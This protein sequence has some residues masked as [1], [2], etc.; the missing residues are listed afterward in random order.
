MD[1]A[2]EVSVRSDESAASLRKDLLSKPPD[3]RVITW[4]NPFQRS[5]ELNEMIIRSQRSST[6]SISNAYALCFCKWGM[7]AFILGLCSFTSVWWLRAGTFYYMHTME[8]M[9]NVY[10]LNTSAVAIY[11]KPYLSAGLR[12]TDVSYG[13]LQDPV[14]GKLGWSNIPMALVDYSAAALP[15]M[16]FVLTILT[17]D[18]MMWTKCTS[19]A[20]YLF[21]LKGALG[22]MTIVPDSIGWDACKKRLKAT[23]VARMKNEIVDPEK[24][25]LSVLLSSLQF[26]L[27]HPGQTRFCADMMFSGHTFTTTLFALSMI[28]LLRKHTRTFRRAVRESIIAFTYVFVITEQII[29]IA[30]VVMNRFHYLT[31]IVVAIVLTFLFFTNGSVSIAAKHWKFWEG[32]FQHLFRPASVHPQQ[33]DRMESLPM[34][35]RAWIQDHP[36]YTILPTDHCEVAGDTWT[37]ICCIPFC[38]FWGRYHVI[39]DEVYHYFDRGDDVDDEI[40]QGLAI[41]PCCKDDLPDDE[42]AGYDS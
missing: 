1:S 37:P 40:S 23:G 20:A 12:P 21:V 31:D 9:E 14:E 4:P 10:I 41:L 18:L 5:I 36:E 11:G 34:E 24:G 19:C 3:E 27:R 30:L 7:P 29:E 17:D 8:R 25:V 39:N 28:E 13:S 2:R 32:N 38:C 6:I 42:E 35:L 15:A 26:E 33:E 16:W 22:F